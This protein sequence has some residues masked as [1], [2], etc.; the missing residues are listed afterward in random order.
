MEANRLALQ[1]VGNNIANAGTAGFVREDANFAPLS[2]TR[3]GSLSIGNGAS[4]A[5]INRKIDVYLN[6]RTR[7]AGSLSAAADARSTI[8]ARTENVF[9][10]LTDSDLSSILDSFAESL[11]NVQN[12][13]ENVSLRSLAIQRGG[14]VA[15]T[16]R[17]IRSRLD[18]LSRDISAEVKA[19]ANDINNSL[20]TVRELNSR[21]AGI[22]ASGGEAGG[23]RTARDQELAK[24]GSKIDI[25]V[26]E[27]PNGTVNVYT[28]DG[29]TPLLFGGRVQEVTTAESTVR[30]VVTQTLVSKD[31]NYP[32]PTTGGRLGG[33]QQARDED[34]GPVIDAL[35]AFASNFIQ[36]FNKLHSSGQGLESYASVTGTNR[37]L[38]PAA[39]FDSANAALSFPPASGA[40]ELRIT[41]P[42]T[43][44]ATTSVITVDLDGIGVDDSLNSLVGKINAAFGS[45]PGPA[46][47][48]ILA[49]GQ[50]QITAPTNVTF[51][52]ASDTSGALASLGINTFFTGRDSR[53]IG[54]NATL[55]ANPGLFAASTNGQRGDVA[56]AVAMAGFLDRPLAG[57]GGSGEPLSVTQFYSGLISDLSSV[58][59]G[60]ATEQSAREASR[61]A[62]ESENLSIS[63]VS[64]DEEAVK[65]LT[66]QQSF[67][68]S[69]RYIST[70]N[71][72]LT[73][74]INLVR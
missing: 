23:L 74:V 25:R 54:I 71:Q 3:F 40:F 15:D 2:P 69:A 43:G 65:L 56:N 12:D 49:T 17:S 44:Q 10:E 46:A 51:S 24:L 60:A 19:T 32:I 20:K 27:Q 57:L 52:F 38:D 53:D 61:D 68:A 62:L 70:I 1:V 59:H 16:I 29:T 47:A 7:Q 42:A 4:V 6:E 48:S 36:E 39:V 66:Y 13:P 30:Q 5:Q 45:P 9:N 58:S 26:I 28:K 73:E 55:R 18:D 34:L 14:L 72:L 63:G 67:Q 37:V 50:L 21:I 31:S 64:L 35:D 33:L 8:L 41:D 11:A 22:E